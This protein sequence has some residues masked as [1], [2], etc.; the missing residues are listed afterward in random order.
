MKTVI[1]ISAAKEFWTE[2]DRH[3]SRLGM[4]RS[5]FIVR[6]VG[7]VMTY[8][9]ENTGMVHVDVGRTYKRWQQGI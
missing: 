3:A 9:A 8:F 5:R 1:G 2:V 7:W 4:S 6:A